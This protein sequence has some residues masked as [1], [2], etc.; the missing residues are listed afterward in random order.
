MAELYILIKKKGTKRFI[1][2]IPTKKGATK[3][4]LAKKLRKQLKPGFSAK[5]VTKM[6]LKRVIEKMSHRKLRRQ[7]KRKRVST[8][9]RRITRRRK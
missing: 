7:V 1:G 6:Q 9:K 2:A 4:T 8:I 5:I 3:T